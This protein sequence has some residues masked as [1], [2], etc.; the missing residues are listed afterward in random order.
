MDHGMRYRVTRGDDDRHPTG[1][2]KFEA[3]EAAARDESE[4][5]PLKTAYIHLTQNGQWLATYING[6]LKRCDL[7]A[8]ADA[9][10]DQ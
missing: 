10:A 2:S 7:S 3:A 8:I 1:F 5:S 4:A 6:R 9:M